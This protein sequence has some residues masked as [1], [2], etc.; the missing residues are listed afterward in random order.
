LLPSATRVLHVCR[1]SLGPGGEVNKFYQNTEVNSEMPAASGYIKRYD[2]T[3]RTESHANTVMPGSRIMNEIQGNQIVKL[4]KHVHTY[5][6]PRMFMKLTY[7]EDIRR[8]TNCTTSLL[9]ESTQHGT[10]NG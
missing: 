7:L 2:V 10:D 4:A 9:H 1:H 3:A 5:T 8:L 6:V